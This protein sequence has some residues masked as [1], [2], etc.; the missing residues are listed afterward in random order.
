MKRDEKGYIVVET[1]LAFV[2][3]LLAMLSILSLVNISVVQSRI[4]YAITEACES[5]S[6]YSYIFQVTGQAKHITGLSGK[7]ASAIS[8]A[9]D[10]VSS[11]NKIIDSG[12]N[13]DANGLSAGASG[14]KET[15]AKIKPKDIL[16]AMVQNMQDILFASCMDA[17]TRHYL[18]NEYYADASV[19]QSGDEYLIQN[20]VLDTVT[21]NGQYGIGFNNYNISL[22]L[23]EGGSTF[24]DKN[25]DI[26]I[27]VLYEIDYRFGG[28]KLPFTKLKIRQVVKT[29]AWL[30]GDG[31]GYS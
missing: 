2:L 6:M 29:R 30:N 22:Q 27:S 20:N 13:L 3:Y 11:L 23:G 7:A 12:R 18:D 25:G 5:I 1:L 17:L 4:H 31:D 9:N 14:L 10:V 8:N 21:F 15:A 19:K 16:A 26:T 24:L 28:L